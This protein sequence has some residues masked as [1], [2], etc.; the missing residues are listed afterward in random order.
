MKYFRCFLLV[1]IAFFGLSSNKSGVTQ[2]SEGIYPG[3]LFADIKNLENVSGTTV[4]LSDFRGQKVLV[5]LWAAYDASSHRDNV[6]LANVIE[7]KAY[8]VTMVSLSFDHSKSV[9]ER[10]VSMD[11]IG[12]DN[13]YQFLLDRQSQDDLFKRCRLD[14]G[15]KNYLINEDGLIVAINLTPE[16][17]S[18]LMNE[19]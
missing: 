5:N 11:A 7:Q 17:L 14:K 4:N 16:S 6:L 10:T 19:N 12:N 8:P 13:S 18:Q 1:S 3:D 15:F 2:P 9:F